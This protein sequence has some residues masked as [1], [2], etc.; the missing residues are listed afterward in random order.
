M[1]YSEAATKNNVNTAAF[2]SATSK[3]KK[4]FFKKC[5]D[6]HI[7]NL[8]TRSQILPARDASFRV[9]G[10]KGGRYSWLNVELEQKEIKWSAYY[11]SNR[12]IP[13]E[14]RAFLNPTEFKSFQ[15]QLKV[16]KFY[17]GRYV[18]FWGYILLKA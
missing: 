18:I 12:D 8:L 13:Q 14:D 6:F 9:N 4:S 5:L 11:Y 7:F 3:T 2:Y 15:W 16:L 17:S 10:C 1:Y